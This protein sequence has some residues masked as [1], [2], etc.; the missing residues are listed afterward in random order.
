MRFSL[1]MK[2]VNAAK[3]AG[4]RVIGYALDADSGYLRDHMISVAGAKVFTH[5]IRLPDYIAARRRR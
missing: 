5:M 2:R 4:M 3:G 1:D